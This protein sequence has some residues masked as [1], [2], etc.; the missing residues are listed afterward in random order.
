MFHILDISLS[1]KMRQFVLLKMLSL[2]FPSLNKVK[3]C[4]SGR[5]LH[6]DDHGL[7]LEEVLVVL[8]DIGMMEHGENLNLRQDAVSVSRAHLLNGN[9][10]RDWD[11]NW[12]VGK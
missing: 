9:L 12:L 3:E 10:N 5:I 11:C 8:D 6:H 1:E 7:V 4:S 2:L